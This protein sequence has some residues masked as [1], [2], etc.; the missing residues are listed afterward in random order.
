MK[1]IEEGLHMLHASARDTKKDASEEEMDTSHGTVYFLIV[2][3]TDINHFM[4]A[5]RV[6]MAMFK[7]L[8]LLPFVTFC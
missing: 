2:N 8:F 3:V 5:L 1:E 6:Q 4:T 7:L